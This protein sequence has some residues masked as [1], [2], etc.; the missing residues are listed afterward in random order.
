MIQWVNKKD[1]WYICFLQ[2]SRED[3]QQQR[4][5]RKRRRGFSS[6]LYPNIPSL[7]YNPML[8]NAINLGQCYF[9]VIKSKYNQKIKN[10]KKIKKFICP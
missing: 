2:I 10:K 6:L 9:D 4:W 8:H 7:T 1:W 3:L 5:L